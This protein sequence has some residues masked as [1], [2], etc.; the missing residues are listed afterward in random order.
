[1]ARI[2]GTTGGGDRLGEHCSLRVEPEKNRGGS[3]ERTNAWKGD[4]MR[5]GSREARARSRAQGR[6]VCGASA[7]RR[8]VWPG[9]RH[10]GGRKEKGS[11]A[12]WSSGDKRQFRTGDAAPGSGAV[13]WAGCADSRLR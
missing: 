12:G 10:T 1:V 7:H 4:D 8:R 6:L 5:P 13:A 3:R 2:L 11:P 9:A